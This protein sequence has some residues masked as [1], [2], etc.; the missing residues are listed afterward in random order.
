MSDNPDTISPAEW[1]A[2]I[3]ELIKNLDSKI[4]TNRAEEANERRIDRNEIA[5][6]RKEIHEVHLAQ[7]EMKT[8]LIEKI[9]CSDHK[10]DLDIVELKSSTN[11]EEASTT[12]K[13]KLLTAITG[14]LTAVGLALAK[15]LGLF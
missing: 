2:L 1:R 14:I 13:G 11:S 9:L 4:D 3:L 7:S 10:Q 15:I 8:Q 12:H 5:A 6:V